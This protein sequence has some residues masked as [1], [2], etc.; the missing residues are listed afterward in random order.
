MQNGFAFLH[1]ISWDPCNEAEDL[2][3]QAKKYK[4]EL[5]DDDIPFEKN[6]LVNGLYNGG[7]VGF[8]RS[9]E[10]TSALSWL[11]SRLE[12]YSEASRA[13]IAEG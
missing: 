11:A 6:L 1:R 10:T 9:N 12:H 4:Q 2:I 5:L 13:R 7:V 3:A 8:R